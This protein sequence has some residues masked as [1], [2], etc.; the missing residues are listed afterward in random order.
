MHLLDKNQNVNFS[1]GNRIY[2]TL[3]IASAMCFIGHGSFGI[4][5]KS[6]WANYFGMFGIGHAA[7]YSLMPV[8]GII[9]ILFGLMLLFYPIKA[10]V[11]WLV[12]WGFVTALLRP[13]SGEPF[14][15]FIERAGNFGAPLALLILSGPD[16]LKN[17]FRPLHADIKIS[18]QTLKSVTLILR[19]VVCLLLAG[20]GWLNLIEK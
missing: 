1:Q 9:D 13:M 19:I 10:V 6:I 7:S 3:R 5:T 17:L 8:V 18:D 16:N 2:Y 15:E 14:P 12:L 11:I 20:H 4:I